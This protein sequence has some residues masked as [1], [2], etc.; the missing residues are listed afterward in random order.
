MPLFIVCFSSPTISLLTFIPGQKNVH[1]KEISTMIA[2]IQDRNVIVILQRCILLLLSIVR[3]GQ[4][5]FE[6]ETLEISR[7]LIVMTIN[8]LYW[9]IFSAFL[10]SSSCI[11]TTQ[12]F[13]LQHKYTTTRQQRGKKPIFGYVYHFNGNAT[14][15]QA[16][17]ENAR[18]R[19]WRKR[20]S[21]TDKTES[22]RPRDEVW[23]KENISARAANIRA[24]VCL[25]EIQHF[26][27]LRFFFAPYIC[28]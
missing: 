17:T 3:V 11:S 14:N 2:S 20:N 6:R 27:L 10:W 16:R 28:W 22:K 19:E 18:R 24:C 12:S 23:R 5:Y 21:K 7:K 15:E 1:W 8:K 4:T 9:C 13:G 25:H 26:S